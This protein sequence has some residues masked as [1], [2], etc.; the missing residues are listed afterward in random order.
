MWASGG[1]GRKGWGGLFLTGEGHATLENQ[2]VYSTNGGVPGGGG[3]GQS[4]IYR[5]ADC[6]AV[7]PG[8]A[9][10]ASRQ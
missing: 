4:G 1:N 9:E 2:E 7:S 6:Q 3:T 10:V 8:P 5:E